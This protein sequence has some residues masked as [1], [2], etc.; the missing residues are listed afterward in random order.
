MPSPSAFLINGE[1][2][3]DPHPHQN[4]ILQRAVSRV[5]YGTGPSKQFWRGNRGGGKSV[6][7]RKG[8]C[9][10][11]AC[12]LPGLTYIVVRRNFPDLETNHLIFVGSEMRKLGGEFNETKRIARYP[13]GSRGF[14]RQCEEFADVEK[15]VGAE[16]AILFVDE[17]PQIDFDYLMLML[18]SLRVAKRQ[19]VQPF[20]TL[21]VF[22]GN[23]TGESIDDL[24]RHFIDKDVTDNEYY[25]PNDWEHVPIHLKDNPAVDRDEYIKSLGPIPLAF[26]SAWIDG[27]R[28]ESRTLFDVKKTKDGKPYHYINELPDIGGVPLLRVPW[29]QVFRAFDMG[30]YPDPAVCLWLVV[31]GRRIIAFHEETWFKTIAKDLAGKILDTTKD[32]TQ[33]QVGVTYVDPTINVKTGSDTV[34]V[35]DILEMNGV[36]CEASI[37]DRV[38]Y[39]DAIHSLL[40]EEV[41][42]GIPRFQIYEPGCPNLAR[43]L[44]KYRWDEKNERKFA[45]HKFDHYGVA[46][47]YFAIS[48]GVLSTTSK[49]EPEVEPVWMKWLR[50]DARRA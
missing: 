4:E 34:T 27:V 20:Y 12:A 10:G 13:N 35:M 30:Y 15:I 47:A 39:A 7:G 49:T 11:L 43:Y 48:S 9:H 23:P 25:D 46:L 24:D 38:L 19:D 2:F 3:F 5:R 36:P 1:V 21:A 29:A 33:G 22:S 37:N 17:A 8:L 16:G 50:E 6:L 41:E 18:P 32:I 28:M 14:Y 31:F 40:G 26:R 44:P 45:D 42:P